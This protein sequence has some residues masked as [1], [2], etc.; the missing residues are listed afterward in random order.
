[1]SNYPGTSKFDV[2]YKDLES[3]ELVPVFSNVKRYKLWTR[4]LTAYRTVGENGNGPDILIRPQLPESPY[5]DV[6][7]GDVILKSP[8]ELGDNPRWGW[9]LADNG[10][11]DYV[12]PCCGYRVNVDVHVRLSYNFCPNCGTRLRR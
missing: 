8:G 6:A 4:F 5:E 7:F 2:L 11:A 9:E 10:W 12:C 1:M 3:G